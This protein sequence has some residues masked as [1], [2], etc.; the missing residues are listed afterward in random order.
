M[1]VNVADMKKRKHEIKAKL[2]AL[3]A[4]AVAE[5]RVFTKEEQVEFEAG[6]GEMQDIGAELDKHY[7]GT[8]LISS[9]NITFQP[10]NPRHPRGNGGSQPGNDHLHG[11]SIGPTQEQIDDVKAVTS[12]MRGDIIASDTPLRGYQSPLSAGLSMAIPVSVLNSTQTYIQNDAFQLAG[13]TIIGTEDTNPLVKPIISA[14]DDPDTFVEGQSA[15]ES[16]PMDVEAFTFR[17]TKYARLTKVSEEL[18]MNSALDLAPE[19]LSELLA[20]LANKF[21][22]DATTALVTALQSNSDCF[23]GSGLDNYDAVLSLTLAVPPRFASPSNVF[24]L[25]RADLRRIKDSRDSQNRP[26]FDA[27]SNT[28]AGYGIVIN[29]NLTRIVF[30]N[31]AAGAYLRKGP[32]I[33]LRLNEAYHS[34]GDIGF[35]ITGYVDSKFMASVSAVEAQPLFFTNIETA[36]S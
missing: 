8:V 7:K 5:N 21:T 26:L 20:S 2:D 25:S 28:L 9:G 31:W 1:F 14:G 3:N 30:G 4:K 34:T 29:D 36:G 33:L 23:V 22:K 6:I 35:K 16:K 32:T 15:T 13:A 18:L 10:E 24:M 19:I 27:T 12:W 17:G 11:L